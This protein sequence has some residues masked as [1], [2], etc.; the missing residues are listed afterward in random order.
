MVWESLVVKRMENF[1]GPPKLVSILFESNGVL[2][3]TLIF[4][5]PE[6][7]KFLCGMLDVVWVAED[8]L[9][10][11][12]EGSP[13]CNSCGLIP[14]LDILPEMLLGS[15]SE[16]LYHVDDVGLVCGISKRF[17]VED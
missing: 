13:C 1:I 8:H 11:T 16:I 5:H 6:G 17:S 10:F 14:L 15:T 2:M 12:G 9:E 4:I 7:D 3:D